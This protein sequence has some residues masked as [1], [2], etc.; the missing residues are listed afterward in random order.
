L[1]FGGI[2]VEDVVK[3]VEDA[4]GEEDILL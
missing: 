2:V 1:G 3:D 4:V